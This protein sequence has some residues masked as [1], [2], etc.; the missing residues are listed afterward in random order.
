M[1]KTENKPRQEYSS[2]NVYPKP[3]LSDNPFENYYNPAVNVNAQSCQKDHLQLWEE[4]KWSWNSTVVPAERKTET[5]LLTLPQMNGFL[6]C[7]V[8]SN[9]EKKAETEEYIFQ[10]YENTHSSQLTG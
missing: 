10:Y 8:K 9:E 6:Y 4:C 1:Y 7:L 2:I 3:L 5:T